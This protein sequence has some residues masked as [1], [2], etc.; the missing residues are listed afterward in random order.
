LK[1]FKV[2]KRIESK[3]KHVKYQTN[4]K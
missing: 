3:A 4:W 1:E 2:P